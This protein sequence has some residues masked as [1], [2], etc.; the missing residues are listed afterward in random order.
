VA[1]GTVYGMHKTTVYLPDDLK[2]AL[3][4]AATNEGCSEA[5]MIRQALRRVVQ[6]KR[7]PRPRVPLFVSGRRGLAERADKALTGFGRA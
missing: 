7:A 5:D 2:R 4:E 1:Y 6:R 3:A